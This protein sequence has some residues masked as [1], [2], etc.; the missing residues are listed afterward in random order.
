MNQMGYQMFPNFLVFFAL[1]RICPIK[2]LVKCR[3]LL[4]YHS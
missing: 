1:L 2:D 3:N 4:Q